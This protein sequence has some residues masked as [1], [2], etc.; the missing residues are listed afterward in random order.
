[1][2]NHTCFL[3][4][5][6]QQHFSQYRVHIKNHILVIRH[7]WRGDYI[8]SLNNL[9]FV[10]INRW[11]LQSKLSEIHR[12]HTHVFSTFFYKRLTSKPKKRRLNT[13][14]DDPKL[15]AAEKRH[16]RVKSWTK[17]VDIF[18]KDFIIIPINEQ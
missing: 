16:A 14:E 13:P 5:N 17:N 2:A 8:I 18:S 6:L 10:C 12:Q 9:W 1:M 15:S 11:L 4:P 3:I 7:I